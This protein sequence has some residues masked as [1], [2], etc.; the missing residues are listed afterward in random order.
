MYNNVYQ[1]YINYMIGA[2]P[3]VQSEF[4]DNTFANINSYNSNANMN[5]EQ[6]YPE[7]YKL[8][9]P[10]IQTACMKNTRPIT[11]GTIDEMVRDI[12]SNFNADD[13]SSS[14]TSD[15]KIQER[16]SRPNNFV[17]N[18]LIR[19]LLIREL[20]GRPGNIIPIRPGFPPQR[21]ETGR[22]PFRPRSLTFNEEDYEVF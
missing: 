21:S 2:T 16:D 10:M 8:I 1:E 15:S 7:L 12:Y 5:L 18:D 3:R 4:Q 11:E 9:Y 19:I 13:V 6:F 20:L 17:L 22:T 14:A